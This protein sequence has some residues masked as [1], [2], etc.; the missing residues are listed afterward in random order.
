MTVVA[1]DSKATKKLPAATV[2]R[3]IKLLRIMR[4]TKQQDLAKVA[5]VSVSHLCKIEAGKHYPHRETLELIAEAL[6]TEADRL[7]R[8]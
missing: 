6:E 8:A 3:K 7:E 1:E 5:K 2:G 4:G